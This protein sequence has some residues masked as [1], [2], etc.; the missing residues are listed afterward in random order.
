MGLTYEQV[1]GLFD[2]RVDGYLVWKVSR[3]NSVEIGDI[4]G[5]QN[6]TQYSEVGVDGRS[7]LSHRVIWL[8]HH[9]YMPEGDLDHINRIKS[10]NRIENLREASRQC[11][12]RNTGNYKTNKS[13]VKGTHT[14]PSWGNVWQARITV[15]GRKCSLGNFKCFDEAVLYRLAAEQCLGWAGCDSSSPAYQYAV[16]NSLIKRRQL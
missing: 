1:R 5:T 3:G 10:D 7:Y 12:S 9:G 8:W 16:N 6:K 4:A 14:H 13:G 11:N 2:Y 15:N